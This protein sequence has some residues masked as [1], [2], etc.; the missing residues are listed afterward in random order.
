MLG[1]GLVN[2]DW[3]VSGRSSTWFTGDVHHH[4]LCI[5]PGFMADEFSV[6]YVF[7]CGGLKLPANL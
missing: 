6:L 4:F 1:S 2:L 3:I 7:G 5:R